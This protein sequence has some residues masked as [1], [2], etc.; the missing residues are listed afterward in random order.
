MAS[1]NKILAPIK[2]NGNVLN[3]LEIHAVA[4]CGAVVIALV[5]KFDKIFSLFRSFPLSSGMK[6]LGHKRS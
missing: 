4:D 2:Q 6:Q 5:Q 1:I 3:Q